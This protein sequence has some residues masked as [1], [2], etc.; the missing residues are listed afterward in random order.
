MVV[1]PEGRVVERTGKDLRDI[2][3][4]IGS[5]GIFRNVEQ[6]GAVE[7]LASATG[8]SAEGWQQPRAP[9]LAI[10][11]QHVLPAIGLLAADEPE[12]AA[13]LARSLITGTR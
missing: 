9:R 7:V 13:R 2:D 11:R 6:G 8:P 12:S 4:L 10:D 5:G 3:L 1:S